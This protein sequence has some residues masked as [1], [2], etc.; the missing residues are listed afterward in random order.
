MREMETPRPKVNVAVT[1]PLDHRL[2]L[3][4][5]HQNVYNLGTKS[6]FSVR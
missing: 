4:N 2:V 5:P 6:L 1:S 3:V